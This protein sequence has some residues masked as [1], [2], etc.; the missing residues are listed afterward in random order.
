MHIEDYIII[1]YDFE[2][3]NFLL[4]THY[5]VV[6]FILINIIEKFTIILVVKV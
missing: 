4:I 5:G 6:N 1:V 3:I 2:K